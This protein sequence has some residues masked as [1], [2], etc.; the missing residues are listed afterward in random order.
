MI[1]DRKPGALLH[2]R[3]HAA[4][5]ACLAKITAVG[6]HRNRQRASS[7]YGLGRTSRVQTLDN[8]RLWDRDRQFRAFSLIYLA[9]RIRH[10]PLSGDL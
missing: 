7:L 9:E 6:G 8:Y 3:R 5:A 4:Q 1:I 2:W 10:R